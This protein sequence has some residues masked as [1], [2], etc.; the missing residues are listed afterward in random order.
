VLA[1]ALATL[2]AGPVASSPA[3]LIRAPAEP[4]VVP[5]TQHAAIYDLFGLSAEN[6]KL[7]STVQQHL[8][9]E[10]YDVKLYRDSTEGAG[11]RGGATL[12]NFVRMAKTA[13]VIVINTHGTDFSGASQVCTVGK[14]LG[15]VPRKGNGDVVTICS[16]HQQ[17][18]VQQVEWYPTLAALHQAYTRYTTS[19]GFKKAWLYESPSDL[20]AGTLAPVRPGDGRIKHVPEGQ[21]PWLGLTTSGIEHFFG[22][23]KVDLIDNLAC[24]SMSFASSY[25]A[26]SYLGHA[27]TAC[28]QFEG[29]DEPLLFDRMTG[30]DNVR[31]RSVVEAFGLGGFADK[32]FQL[33]SRQDV[34]LSPA[35]ESASP[36][37]GDALAVGAATRGTVAFDAKMDTSDP[38]SVVN[39]SGCGATISGATW[40]DTGT[41]LSYAI[42]V[43]KEAVGG[44]ATLTV[45]ASAAKA[46]S[47]DG[48]N[49]DLD[50]NQTPSGDSDGGIEPNGDDQ[51]IH[52]A[53]HQLTFPVQVDYSG[54]YRDDYTNGAF[55]FHETLIWHE[56]QTYRLSFADASSSN[57]PGVQSLTASGTL[58]TTGRSPDDSCTI[59]TLPGVPTT[60]FVSSFQQ[61]PA[62]Y[63]ASFMA[64]MP[65]GTAA[66]SLISV[67]GT[68]DNCFLDTR[69]GIAPYL[70]YHPASGG[71]HEFDPG[72]FLRD[73]WYGSI[74]NVD[75]GALVS[76]PRTVPFNADYVQQDFIGGSDHVVVQASATV[77][78]TGPPTGA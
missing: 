30:H 72:G 22:G 12:A 27:S 16:K 64:P 44:P 67:T 3:D 19:G 32:L 29:Q 36:A 46:A 69:D 17:E 74:P 58:T 37:E 38:S 47:G 40:N 18:P 13:S 9:A 62:N 78:L 51:V 73:G 43:P 28:S 76:G 1:S 31:V 21:R 54:T 5:K 6:R 24:H 4:P 2:L 49:A 53:C 70:Y 33:S 60:M 15:T 8:A 68:P 23:R 61:N 77:S 75:L 63:V 26:E 14:G 45:S 11:S 66:G 65:T 10:G 25:G 50:G 56:S 71:V 35:V 20:W 41:V 55:S 34:V 57:V 52:V 7:L 59:S 42:N 39:V 48:A